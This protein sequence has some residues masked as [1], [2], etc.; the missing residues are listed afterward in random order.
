ML[1]VLA[2]AGQDRSR[3]ATQLTGTVVTH[4]LSTVDSSEAHFPS[5]PGQ[6]IDGNRSPSSSRTLDIE[7]ITPGGE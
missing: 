3:L 7:P 6:N 2:I 1:F 4:A 5:G